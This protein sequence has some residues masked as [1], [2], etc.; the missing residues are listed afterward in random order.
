MKSKK[1]ISIAV[2]ERDLSMIDEQASINKMSRSTYIVSCA[3][4]KDRKPT[5][6]FAVHLERIRAVLL[7]AKGFIPKEIMDDYNK[8]VDGIWCILNS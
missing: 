7:D 2:S 5:P 1:T 8:E 3:T 6:E 4:D